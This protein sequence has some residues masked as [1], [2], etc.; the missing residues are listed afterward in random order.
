N[1]ILSG[2][3]GNDFLSGGAG[4]DTYLF[5]L[6]DGHDTIDNQGELKS[7]GFLNYR[8][9]DVDKIRF[10]DGIRA[11]MLS[12]SRRNSDLVIAIDSQ[13]SITIKNWFSTGQTQLAAR[14]DFF[15]FADG[16]QLNIYN[17]Y[18][19]NPVITSGIAKD[20][21]LLSSNYNDIYRFG[22][23][24]GHD[25]VT[26]LGGND[27][28]EFVDGIKPSEIRFSRQGADI[29]VT[30]IGGNSSI[31]LKN[32]FANAT[33]TT[34]RVNEGNV[35]ET[36]V[37]ADGTKL[38]WDEVLNNRLQMFGTDGNDTILGN[39][40]NDIL[41]GGKG[42]DFLSGGAGNDTYLF[43]LGDGHDTIDNQGELKS[44]GFLNYRKSD[45]DKIRFGDGIRADMLSCSRR[46]SDLV[47]AIDSQNSITIKNWF[48]TGQTQLA[49]RVDFF[50]FAD[51]TQLNIYNWYNSN[52]VITSGIAKDETLLSSNYND[53]YRFGRHSGH[54]QVTELGGNDKLE[55]VDGIKP[56]EI[57]FSRQGAD[58][59]VTLIGGN[60]SITLKNIFANATSAT[61]RVNEGNVIET[62]VFADGTKLTWDEVLNNRLQMFGTDGNDTI[63]GNKGNDIL[64]GGKGNDFLS[65]G[66]GNDTYLFNLG[67]GHDTIDNQGELKS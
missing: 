13:N 3:K 6:G 56:S 16:T 10:G 38:T 9:S 43:N 26:E 28:L 14:V 39:K 55:F 48:S 54:D 50:E 40:G 67:D 37:F 1:D 45:V 23:H 46:N 47:I 53:I 22:R 36:F 31:T 42:N 57:R 32:I 34:A 27:K 59:K 49:A 63:L 24:S 62:F 29:K 4:N 25:Q 2:G 19:S 15:E 61:A 35:I 44:V 52:P 30:L 66:A 41:S 8:K 58:I 21:T 17:W 12:C 64:S 7:V 18:N 51:G 60:S 65:G 11:D 5:N 20:E 33:S